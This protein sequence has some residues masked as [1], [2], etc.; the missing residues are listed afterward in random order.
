MREEDHVR[1]MFLCKV[2]VNEREIK[3][4]EKRIEMLTDVKFIEEFFYAT[5]EG[6]ETHESE[7]FL[8]HSGD[9]LLEQS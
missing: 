5:R 9:G 1:E 7:V 2:Q 3:K 6:R 4:R 8:L